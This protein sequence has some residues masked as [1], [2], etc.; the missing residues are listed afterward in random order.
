[1]STPEATAVEAKAGLVAFEAKLHATLNHIPLVDNEGGHTFQ[2]DPHFVDVYFRVG[3]GVWQVSFAS[4]TGPRRLANGSNS[5]S[6]RGWKHLT[7][8]CEDFPQWLTDLI[9]Q[10]NPRSFP[11]DI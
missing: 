4:I 5:T 7:P 1:M 2:F 6:S 9:A 8:G 11:S 10:A 3:N